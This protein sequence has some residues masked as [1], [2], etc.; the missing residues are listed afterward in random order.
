MRY[1]IQ[2][3]QLLIGSQPLETRSIFPFVVSEMEV[4]TFG[5]EL[6]SGGRVEE[7]GVERVGAE[8]GDDVR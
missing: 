4:Q 3:K 2:L 6:T 7:R 8:S 5:D 1:V